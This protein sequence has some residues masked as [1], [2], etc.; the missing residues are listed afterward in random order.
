MPALPPETSPTA[1]RPPGSRRRGSGV[2]GAVGGTGR[3]AGRAGRA[4]GASLAR[5]LTT[6]FST[7]GPGF[8]DLAVT[9]ATSTS[10]DTL[11]ALALAGTL[12]FQVP[13][14]EARGNVALYLLLTAAPF[15][16]IGPVLGVLLDRRGVAAR[17]ALVGSALA[18]AVV[19]V[20]LVGRLDTLLLFPLAFTFLVL[21]R[22]HG[23]AR[24]A[25]LPLALDAPRAL[26]AANGRLAWI[27]VLSG[28]ATVPVGLLATW[29]AGPNG[30]LILAAVVF[31]VAALVGR[32][33]PQPGAG[34][35]LGPDQA[36]LHLGR[37]VRLAQVA[38]A[39]VR[40][41]NG[42]LILLLAFAFRDID[43]PLADFGAVLAAAGAGFGAA[44]LVAP[45]LA[46]RLKEQPMVV[47]ALA[48]EAAAA[49]T[50]G[51]WFGLP[52]AAF[53]AASAG[54]AWGVAKLAFDGLLQS[55]VPAGRRGAAFTRSETVFQLA[56][57]AGAVLPTAVAIPTSVAL[58][59]AGF[60][61]L[62]AQVVYIA[63]LLSAVEP[64]PV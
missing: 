23:I 2:A 38:T 49:F 59:A 31:V 22:A 20:A 47:A 30:A 21:S 37:T 17:T 46:R 40:F 33:L 6:L 32:R 4:V 12:F 29:L 16:V 27:G 55:H 28:A 1:D 24:N 13:T 14:A 25:L 56:W 41:L 50:A 5:R 53:L 42:L 19:V 10:G 48:M 7:G 18:R 9:H 15:A 61:A 57:V 54:F 11:V 60:T 62:A 58:P 26:V 3:L 34:V 45:W 63:R 44:S 51:Q 36:P 35:D 43:A 39:V 64:P 52:A 8:R